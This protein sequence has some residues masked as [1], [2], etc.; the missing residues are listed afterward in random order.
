MNF[1]AGLHLHAA[2]LEQV[3]AGRGGLVVKR[4]LNKVEVWCVFFVLVQLLHNK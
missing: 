4:V 3:W 1:S 2:C